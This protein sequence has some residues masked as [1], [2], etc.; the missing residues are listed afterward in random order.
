MRRYQEL[1]EAK[2]ECYYAKG[3]LSLVYLHRCQQSVYLMGR[4]KYK[5]EVNEYNTQYN[6]KEVAKHWQRK[7][8]SASLN[9]HVK[10]K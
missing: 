10:Y 1:E 9:K 8:A 4:V 2:Q 3:W 5:L 6:L 7:K